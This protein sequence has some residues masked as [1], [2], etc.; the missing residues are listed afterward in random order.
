MDIKPRLNLT[1][2]QQI[3]HY[4]LVAIIL[5]PTAFSIYFAIIALLLFILQYR[6]LYFKRIDIECTDEQFNEAVR[7]TVEKF[8]W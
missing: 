2:Q 4:S 6:R 3:V 7:R 8:N 1:L 5:I